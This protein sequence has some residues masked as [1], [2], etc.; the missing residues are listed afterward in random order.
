MVNK[1]RLIKLTQD[2]IRINSENPPGKEFKIAVFVKKLLDKHGFKTRLYEFAKGRTNIVATLEGKDKS[3]SLLLTPHL[4]TVPVG[5]GWSYPAFSGLIRNGRIYGRGATDCKGNVAAG[6]ES[7]IS[8]AEEKQELNHSLVFAATAD[9]ETGSKLGLIPLVDK[10]ILKPS[11]AVILDSDVFNIIVAQKGLIH[12]KICLFGKKSHG[13]YPERGMNAID[14]ATK[15]ILK[16]KK[17]KFKY[18][19]HSLLRAPTVNI[20]IIRG[21]DKVNMVA[22]WC[23]VEVDLRFLPGMDHRKILKE[24]RSIIKSVTNKFKL[25]V[26]DVQRPCEIDT[27]HDLVKCLKTTS[28]R[29]AGRAK[30]KG[31]EGATVITFLAARKVPSVATGFGT[32]RCA[33]TTDEYVTIFIKVLRF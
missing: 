6:I 10:K 15:V 32:S 17:H 20:G 12:F 1:K 31:S 14:L 7:I 8:L 13:A 5:K 18:K 26:H 16:L 19:R 21:G 24:V 28:K 3:K 11:A 30:L 25:E 23:D 29:I 22:D 4:D 33:H 2:L 27:R 9:E